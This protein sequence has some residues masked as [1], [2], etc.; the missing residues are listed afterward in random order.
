[1]DNQYCVNSLFPT[2]VLYKDSEGLITES[3]LETSLS[4]LEQY[5]DR[6]FHSPCISTVKT[7]ASVLK[8][9]QF[10]QIEQFISQAVGVFLDMH[11]IN[12]AGLD[13]LD[14]WLNLYKPGSYQDLHTHHDSMISGVFYIKS[15]GAKD[16]IFQ[17]PWHFQQPRMPD[18][19]ERDLTNSH[20]VEYNSV[21]GRVILF[22]SHAMH[23]TIPATEERISLSFNIG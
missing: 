12:P 15:A 8:L 17:A 4:L 16:F 6:P 22:M 10:K 1:M 5:A 14:S 21:A 2:T 9:P 20:N 11:K 19:T 3:V 18:Y 13:F 7:Y 23:R